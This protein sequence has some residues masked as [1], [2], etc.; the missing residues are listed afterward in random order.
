MKTIPIN[1]GIHVDC[2]VE[3]N[4]HLSVLR[5]SDTCC[6][7]IMAMSSFIRQLI[8]FLRFLQFLGSHLRSKSIEQGFG[9]SKQTVGCYVQEWTFAR[10]HGFKTYWIS[11]SQYECSRTHCFSE[12]RLST[13]LLR[14]QISK[15]LWGYYY[16]PNACVDYT[17]KD[18]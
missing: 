11:Q 7:D 15:L 5:C 17:R 13:N 10:I 9:T 3:S 2:V 18:E 12:L 14:M 6:A 1:I 4:H 8:H 16:R